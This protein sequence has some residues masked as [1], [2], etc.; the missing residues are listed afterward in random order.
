MRSSIRASKVTR[1]VALLLIGVMAGPT[2]PGALAGPTR[3][4]SAAEQA[5]VSWD[6]VLPAAPI[7]TRLTLTLASGAVLECRLIEV[8]S[9]AILVDDGRVRKGQFTARTAKD[10]ALTFSRADVTQVSMVSPPTKYASTGPPDA[11][12]VRFLIA[13]WGVGKKVDLRTV[14]GERVRAR[15]TSIAPGGFT[16]VSGKTSDLAIAYSDVVQLRRGGKSTGA[17]IAIWAAV[18]FGALSGLGGLICIYGGG[19][20]G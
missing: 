13:S 4:Q 3:T 10:G 18:T 12:V 6:L 16:A 17:R 15:I 1:R 8:G 9:D 7:G 11:A 2:A 5:A 19:C 14:E 20:S